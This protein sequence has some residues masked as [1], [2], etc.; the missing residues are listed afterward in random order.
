MS[1]LQK[2]YVFLSFFVNFLSNFLV[3]LFLQSKHSNNGLPFFYTEMYSIEELHL[4]HFLL[5][6]I[7]FDKLSTKVDRDVDISLKLSINFI[8]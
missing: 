5:S 1:P 6:W 3:Y 7:L 8:L 2:L 4:V